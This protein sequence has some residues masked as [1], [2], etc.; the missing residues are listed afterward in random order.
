MIVKKLKKVV[1][2]PLVHLA[3][4]MDGNRRWA[5]KNKFMVWHGHRE[6]I[7]AAKNVMDFCLEKNISLLSLYT[8][9]L[10]NFNRSEEEKKYFFRL[11]VE[12]AFAK[13]NEGEFIKKK[14]KIRFVGD[15]SCFPE[16]V[17]DACKEIEQKTAGLDMLHVN[18]LFGYGGRQEIIDGVNK[19]I[20]KIKT[21]ELSLDKLTPDLFKKFLWTG[22]IP[23]PDLI[24]RTGGVQRLSNFFPYQS[25]YSELYFL[26]C[27]WPEI[28][29]ADLEQAVSYYNNV[30]RNFGT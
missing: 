20:S 15:L 9:S 14:V 12:E 19:V 22:D 23:D 27:L 24:I 1:S 2:K 16:D 26:N 18:L 17:K 13:E 6:G 11:F 10:E 8:F 25:V 29:K 7:Q 4:I 5:I 28:S 30:R 21:K 3:C